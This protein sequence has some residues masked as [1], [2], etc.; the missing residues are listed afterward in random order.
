MV[1]YFNIFRS[2]QERCHSWM[3][4]EL[5]RW[6]DEFYLLVYFMLPPGHE[7]GSTI[8]YT[9]DTW[10]TGSLLLYQASWF[11][12][13]SNIFQPKTHVS[14]KMKVVYTPDFCDTTWYHVIPYLLIACWLVV[15]KLLYINCYIILV[16]GCVIL[17]S[18]YVMSESTSPIYLRCRCP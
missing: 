7:M 15:P 8:T 14:W 2:S 17:M 18:S 10:L 6:V 9:L 3:I 12:V 5:T 16:E 1:P 11:L 13:S 4:P